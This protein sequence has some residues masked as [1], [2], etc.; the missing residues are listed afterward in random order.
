MTWPT[1]AQPRP[2]AS[3]ASAIAPSL[4][5]TPVSTTAA[6][7][8]RARMYADT[9][10][11]LTRCQAVGPPAVPEPDPDPDGASPEPA[12]VDAEAAAPSPGG[13]AGAL[14]ADDARGTRIRRGAAQPATPSTATARPARPRSTRNR[15]RL[16]GNAALIAGWYDAAGGCGSPAGRGHHPREAPT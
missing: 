11:R 1:F 7:P 4:P 5:G 9:K 3:R 15:R 12:A 8:P 14:A 6:S 16:I 13:D 10:P 2:A